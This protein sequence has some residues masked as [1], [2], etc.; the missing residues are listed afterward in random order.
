MLNEDVILIDDNYKDILL[1]FTQANYTELPEYEII[2]IEG[3][4]HNRKFTIKVI[5]N[6][7][8]LGKG[9]GKTK[10]DAEQ[11]AA[12]QACSQLNILKK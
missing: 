12:F 8:T 10:K 1:R 3:P 9:E 2:N 11:K 6:K 4:P 7:E 5:V